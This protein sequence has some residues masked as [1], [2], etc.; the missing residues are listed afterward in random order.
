VG[1][2]EQVDFFDQVARLVHSD[3]GM[4]C[5]ANVLQD[6]SG[7]QIGDAYFAGKADA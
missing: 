3:H 1:R 5:H 6:H 4:E 2:V 7:N